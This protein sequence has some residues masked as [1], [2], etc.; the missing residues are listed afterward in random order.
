[1]GLNWPEARGS[2]V[3]ELQVPWM[4]RTLFLVLDA[5]LV[6]TLTRRGIPRGRIWTETEVMDLV[7]V[8]V[9]RQDAIKIA[10]TKAQF[11]ARVTGAEQGGSIQELPKPAA[12]IPTN[13][14]LCFE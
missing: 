10:G 5:R 12:P 3:I 9:T 4:S 1:M 14:S 13:L 2:T 11:S 7:R 6:S 8:G